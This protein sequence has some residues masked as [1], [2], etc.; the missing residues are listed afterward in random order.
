MAQPT[1]SVIAHKVLELFVQEFGLTTVVGLAAS[2][3]SITADRLE[4]TNNPE[5]A[6]TAREWRQ[7]GQTIRAIMFRL[8]H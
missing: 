2:V 4:S 6:D 3:A 8:R 7:D 5:Q 1:E